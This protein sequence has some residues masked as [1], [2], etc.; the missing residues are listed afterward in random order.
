MFLITKKRK[1]KLKE[2]KIKR[3]IFFLF[4]ED[5]EKN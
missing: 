1:T 3:V 2:I 4:L 5:F